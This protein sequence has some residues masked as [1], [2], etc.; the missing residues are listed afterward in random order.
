MT[1]LVV[2]AQALQSGSR[3]RGIGRYS[4]NLLLAIVQQ[5]PDIDVTLVLSGALPGTVEPV[6]CAFDGLV[7]QRNIIVSPLSGDL[8]AGSAQNMS[9]RRV[10]EQVQSEFFHAL[11]PDVI[12]TLS[13]FETINENVIPCMP[14]N[15]FSGS[16]PHAA[17]LYDVIPMEMPRTFLSAPGE[18]SYYEGQLERLKRCDRVLSI[19]EAS[20]N[21]YLHLSSVPSESVDVIGTGLVHDVERGGLGE[22]VSSDTRCDVAAVLNSPHRFVLCVGGA[23]PHKQI[24]HLI[25]AFSGTGAVR[26]ESVRLVLVGPLAHSRSAIRERAERHGLADGA[27]VVLDRVPDPDLR[28][29]Y[30]AA[31]LTVCPSVAE[32]FGFTPFEAALGG[33]AVIV[34]SNRSVRELLPDE[35]LWF[36]PYS[37]VSLR[38]KIDEAL[39]DPDFRM[40]SVESVRGFSA[41]HTWDAVAGRAVAA[42]KNCVRDRA[43]DGGGETAGTVGA[44]NALERIAVWRS[45]SRTRMV[46]R[47]HEQAPASLHYARIARSIGEVVQTARIS[48]PLAWDCYVDVSELYARDAGSGI[49]RVTRNLFW[50]L[51]RIGKEQGFE[52]RAVV[53]HRHEGH[54]A[55]RELEGVQ[56]S[57]PL[58]T[59]TMGA[60][61]RPKNGD[62]WLGLDLRLD[63]DY[64]YLASLRERG[65]RTLAVVHDLIPTRYPFFWPHPEETSAAFRGWLHLVGAGD[66]CICISEAVA[67]DLRNWFRDNPGQIATRGLQRQ[68]ALGWAHL[69]GGMNSHSVAPVTPTS[70]KLNLN[71]SD[72]DGRSSAAPRVHRD[73]QKFLMVG[74]YEPRKGH[75][76]VLSAFRDLWRDGHEVRLTF[77]GRPGW[78]MDEF[79]IEARREASVNPLFE[80]LDS[81]SDEQLEEAYETADCVIVASFGEGFGLP[82]V[83]AFEHGCR[84]LA[85]DLPVFREIA[86]DQAH[87]FSG[88]DGGDLA[89]AVL[90][91]VA[92]NA[93]GRVPIPEPWQRS[94]DEVAEDYLALMLGTPDSLKQLD[95]NHAGMSMIPREWA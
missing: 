37:A 54:F 40:H 21:A 3:E 65:V 84:V 56:P 53:S 60:V 17:I 36:D 61:I 85:R 1:R 79:M 76:Q 24:D 18:R 89:R 25:D 59:A 12:L 83:E 93:A 31:A 80:V 72:V 44:D 7:S 20:R 82:I 6:R 30:Q 14:A 74:T 32:G 33:S 95:P 86:G 78:M 50:S 45:M 27:I 15:Q 75:A 91:W 52:V 94:W 73:A 88:D 55:F 92:D 71:G 67:G 16:V 64:D 29:L 47:V 34:A 26:S 57:S 13:P 69:S 66:G 38:R 90:A 58:A 49:Q 62:V 42:L 77:A 35:S 43:S 9:L 48:D 8:R 23:D 22:R 5:H 81:P 70:Q 63:T 11:N 46:N 39:K 10:Y 2:D 41:A 68:F 19:S 87:Y 51:R 4:Q 28:R